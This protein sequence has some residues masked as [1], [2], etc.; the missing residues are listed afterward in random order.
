MP[1]LLPHWKSLAGISF[2][3]KLLGIQYIDDVTITFIPELGSLSL[4]HDGR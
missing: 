4:Q 2:S 3:P 1:T